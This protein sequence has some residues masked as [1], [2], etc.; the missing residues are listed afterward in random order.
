VVALYGAGAIAGELVGLAWRPDRP[1]VAATAVGFGWAA[2]SAALTVG[3]PLAV[4]G[5]AAAVAG[6]VSTVFGILWTTTI[7]RRVPAQALSRVSSYVF[8]GACSV[9]PIGLALAGPVADATSGNRAGGRGRLAGA[10]QQRAARAAGH[11]GRARAVTGPRR[12]PVT[13]VDSCY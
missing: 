10:R 2:P 1:L 13:T 12:G 3:A 7:Q 9:G 4:V 5:V 8:F 11:P 6:A